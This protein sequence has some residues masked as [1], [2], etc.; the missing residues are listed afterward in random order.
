MKRQFLCDIYTALCQLDFS[1]FF[2]FVSRMFGCCC[3]NLMIFY[4][5]RECVMNVLST[6][7]LVQLY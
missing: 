7:K 2:V 3:C 5:W 6:T 1:W 4:D